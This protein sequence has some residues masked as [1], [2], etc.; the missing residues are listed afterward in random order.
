MEY[1]NG[2]ADIKWALTFG[3]LVCLSLT[4][5][6]MAFHAVSFIEYRYGM[7]VRLGLW[8]MVYKKVIKIQRLFEILFVLNKKLFFV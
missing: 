6:M 2:T 4:L 7:Q 3:F 1:F 5:S 8:G